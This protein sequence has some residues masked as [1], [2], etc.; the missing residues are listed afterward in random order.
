MQL[1]ITSLS[2]ILFN[3]DIACFGEFWKLVCETFWHRASVVNFGDFITACRSEFT[4]EEI[5]EIAVANLIKLG[6][7]DVVEGD[8]GVIS[9]TTFAFKGELAF[10]ANYYRL[11]LE[12]TGRD[13]ELGSLAAN[14]RQLHDKLKHSDIEINCSPD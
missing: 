1:K 14:I 2:T 9:F 12:F 5:R 4:P 7:S 8:K 11:A 6:F 10:A 13:L 3:D